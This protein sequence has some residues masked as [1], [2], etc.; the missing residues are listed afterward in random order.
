[1]LHTGNKHKKALNIDYDKRCAEADGIK[2]LVR[3][4]L[5]TRKT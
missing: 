1:M 4:Y 2:K 5:M 3:G